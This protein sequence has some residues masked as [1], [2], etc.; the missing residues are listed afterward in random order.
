M[1]NHINY[2][3]IDSQQVY[4]AEKSL[5]WMIDWR[6]FRVY[7]KQEF[8]IENAYVHSEYRETDIALYEEYQKAGFICV[9][10]HK[11]EIAK[12]DTASEK[13][14]KTMIHNYHFDKAVIITGDSNFNGTIEFLISQN[15][16]AGLLIT[17]T[18]K[19]SA[20][21]KLKAL[22]PFLSCMNDLEG[23]IKK[24]S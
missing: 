13:I 20:L 9:F 21:S 14:L 12:K 22:T 7:L 10:T 8:N 16:L 6:K 3:F 4:L 5:G 19:Y 11:N 1:E 2:A 23:R 15:K 18:T 24:L 17:N